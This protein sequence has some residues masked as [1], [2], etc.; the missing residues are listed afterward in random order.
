MTQDIEDIRETL[1]RMLA[2]AQA[3]RSAA[4]IRLLYFVKEWAADDPQS[5]GVQYIVDA[6][7]EILEDEATLRGIDA[8]CHMIRC[9]VRY[10]RGKG[11]DGDPH[12]T[13]NRYIVDA[14]RSMLGAFDDEMRA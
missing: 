12:A 2:R 14:L 6:L 5:R 7:R 3:R 1:D 9:G 10:E 13:V 4:L 8:L 11:E